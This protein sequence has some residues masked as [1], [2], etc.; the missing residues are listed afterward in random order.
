MLNNLKTG[1]ETDSELKIGKDYD[2]EIKARNTG[3]IDQYVRVTIYKSWVNVTDTTST[4]GWFHGDTSP[5]IRDGQYDLAN[6]ILSYKNEDYNTT[7]WVKDTDPKSDTEER[8]IFYYK[9]TLIPGEETEPLL[10]TLQISPKV[11]VTPVAK[12]VGGTTYYTYA[13]DGLGFV[14]KA[15]VDA[16][17]THHAGKAIRSAWGMTNN[18]IMA[19]MGISNPNE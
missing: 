6:I 1:S 15:E 18:N 4:N 11:A 19:Q 14:V 7:N 2:F 9:G 17:Q 10:T 16:V 8:D 5:K 3:T 12:T 13:Y